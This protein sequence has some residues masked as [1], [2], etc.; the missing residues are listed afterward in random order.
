MNFIP[1]IPEV[2]TPVLAAHALALAIVNLTDT[3]KDDDIWRPSTV[4][5]VRGW[6]PPLSSP[7]WASSQT[8]GR[9]QGA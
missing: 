4:R 5:R 2:V 1:Y 9:D 7:S 8:S 6:P 3:P